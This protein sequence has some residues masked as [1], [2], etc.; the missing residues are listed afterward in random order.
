MENDSF[1]NVEEEE[2]QEENKMA[3]RIF[4]HS[5]RNEVVDYRWYVEDDNERS[6]LDSLFDEGKNQNKF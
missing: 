1:G 3:V 5:Y 6:W 4:V 2:E